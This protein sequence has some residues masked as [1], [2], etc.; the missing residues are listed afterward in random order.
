MSKKSIIG[1]VR[2]HSLMGNVMSRTGY[3]RIQ[4]A[5]PAAVVEAIETFRVEKKLLSRTAALHELLRR[6]LASQNAN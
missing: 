2:S 5:I 1:L 4:I 3:Y 6:G